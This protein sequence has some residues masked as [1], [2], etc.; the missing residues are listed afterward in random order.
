MQRLLRY[1]RVPSPNQQ[2][3]IGKFCRRLKFTPRRWFW[4]IVIGVPI[5]LSGYVAIR[6][7]S[8]A[9]MQGAAGNVT[10][11]DFNDDLKWDSPVGECYKRSLGRLIYKQFGWR[12]ENLVLVRIRAVFEGPVRQLKIVQ[13]N[14]LSPQVSSLVQDYH[15]LERF[16][17]MGSSECE[18]DSD[19]VSE[20]FEVLSTRQ[21]LESVMLWDLKLSGDDLAKLS[22]LPNLKSIHLERCE[23]DGNP[24]EYLS[25]FSHLKCLTFSGD[26]GL[27][28]EIFEL[29]RLLGDCVFTLNGIEI[30]DI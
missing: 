7:H 11:F 17:L 10:F 21:S 16:N 18:F 25:E 8:I 14:A 2:G 5:L 24:I 4:V 15:F 27:E 26:I 6:W 23:I 13:L 19:V 12:Q 1:N 20:L 30:P 3:W 29:K 22:K 9:A 28:M